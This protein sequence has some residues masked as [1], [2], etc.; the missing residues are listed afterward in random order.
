MTLRLKGGT[1]S[2]EEKGFDISQKGK[3]KMREKIENVV[4]R[5]LMILRIIL[6]RDI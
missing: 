4:L 5:S 2:R 6:R 3:K 1:G